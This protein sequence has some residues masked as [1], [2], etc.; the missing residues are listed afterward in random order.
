MLQ[1][2]FTCPSTNQTFPLAVHK[3]GR[4]QPV[5]TSQH[6]YCELEIHVYRDLASF[7]NGDGACGSFNA[8]VVDCTIPNPD[9]SQAGFEILHYTDWFSSESYEGAGYTL[10]SNAYGFLKT[11]TGDAHPFA[12]NVRLYPQL[13]DYTTGTVDV[14]L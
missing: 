4:I 12:S 1:K 11:I 13:P 6:K 10:K 8:R 9:E 7:N 2:S 3:V 14:G 5:S